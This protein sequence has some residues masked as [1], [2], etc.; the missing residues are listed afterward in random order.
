MR[1]G[2]ANSL[3]EKR[4]VMHFA[5][6]VRK[7]Y[8]L[9]RSERPVLK[10]TRIPDGS[11]FGQALTEW[12]HCQIC[13]C[14]LAVAATIA[15]TP[16]SQGGDLVNGPVK[17]GL[18][19]QFSGLQAFRRDCWSWSNAMRHHACAPETP[20]LMAFDRHLFVSGDKTA[21]IEC[22][23]ETARMHQLVCCIAYSSFLAFFPVQ[24]Q[25]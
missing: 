16:T 2:E 10:H 1:G 13:G 20:R 14:C 7:Q 23:N 24:N 25:Q 18:P 4:S 3:W 11:I 22:E 15:A 5:Y 21:R 8:R 6:H 9:K 19:R 12:R 17:I